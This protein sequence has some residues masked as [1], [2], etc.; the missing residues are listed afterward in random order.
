[1]HSKFMDG[2]LMFQYWS[3]ELAALAAERA[4]E[5]NY[6]PNYARHKY[7]KKHRYVGENIGVSRSE[8][9]TDLIWY[10]FYEGKNYNYYYKTCYP[11]Y[12]YYYT[13][14]HYLQVIIV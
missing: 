6:E 1:M 14:E 12:Y 5:C 11:D 9:I 7:Y 8:S 10:W 3:E 13:C 2:A 4:R